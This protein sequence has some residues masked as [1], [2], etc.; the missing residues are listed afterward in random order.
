VATQELELQ[1]DHPQRLHGVLVD[2]SRDPG[3]LQVLGLQ[4]PH[5]QSTTLRSQRSEVADVAEHEGDPVGGGIGPDGEP[6]VEEVE[7]L[8][9]VHRSLG[10]HGLTEAPV[11][12]RSD[13][14]RELRPDVLPEELADLSADQAFRGRVHEADTPVPVEREEPVVD[15]VDGSA[16]VEQW[17][18]H[19]LGAIPAALDHLWVPAQP[20]EC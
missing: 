9:D 8:L 16:Q 1:G 7:V 15:T 20:Y 14:A 11:H 13:G 2:V 10:H 5:E 12:Q 6:R 4:Q 18:R 19:K 17:P 3:A